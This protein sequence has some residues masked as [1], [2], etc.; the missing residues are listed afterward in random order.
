MTPDEAHP[1]VIRLHE[2]QLGLATR[3]WGGPAAARAT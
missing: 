1:A 3:S 2:V